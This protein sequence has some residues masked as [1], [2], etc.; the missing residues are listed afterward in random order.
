MIDTTHAVDSRAELARPA[1]VVVGHALALVPGEKVVILWS[2]VGSTVEVDDV[3][4]VSGGRLL[5]DD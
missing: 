5:V 3:P 4:I 2:E 1:S